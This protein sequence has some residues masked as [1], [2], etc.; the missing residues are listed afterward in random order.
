MGATLVALAADV[1]QRGGGGGGGSGNAAK[2]QVRRSVTTRAIV[3]TAGD[4]GESG[5]AR[6]S[7]SL[8]ARAGKS[9][10][11]DSVVLGRSR[12]TQADVRAKPFDSLRVEQLK[13]VLSRAQRH[14]LAA[15][16]VRLHTCC[17]VSSQ[18]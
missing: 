8:Q 14:H 4:G 10:R 15:L 17:S 7:P 18:R 6:T 13:P 11:R 1:D 16:R 2:H 5:S 9:E 3:E 12:Q